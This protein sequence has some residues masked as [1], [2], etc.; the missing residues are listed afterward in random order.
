VFGQYCPGAADGWLIGVARCDPNNDD[1]QHMPD[2]PMRFERGERSYSPSLVIEA[3]DG[4]TVQYVAGKS[5]D[6]V[7]FK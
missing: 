1:D 2:W 3:P 5:A 6:S 4:C 7:S